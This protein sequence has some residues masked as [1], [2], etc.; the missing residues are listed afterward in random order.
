MEH[1]NYGDESFYSGSTVVLRSPKLSPNAKLVYNILLSY[2][3][4]G[5]E[6]FVSERRI[7]TDS[8]IKSRDKVSKALQEL[9]DHCLIIGKIVAGSHGGRMGYT[10]CEIPESFTGTGRVRPAWMLRL[11]RD[12]IS[13]RALKSYYGKY[14]VYPIK[15]HHEQIVRTVKDFELWQDILRQ[16]QPEHGYAFQ[17]AFEALDVLAEYVAAVEATKPAKRKRTAQ[18]K[19]LAPLPELAPTPVYDDHD[20]QYEQDDQQEYSTPE[21][22]PEPARDPGRS[23]LD[24]VNGYGAPKAQTEGGA[25]TRMPTGFLPRRTKQNAT[26]ANSGVS[27][28]QHS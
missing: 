15:E 9:K 12:T 24:V 16:Y 28:E 19:K 10:I 6:T 14:G 11:N 2:T 4:E 26:A 7:Y 18:P 3:D 1:G 25:P 27:A 8:C 21:P 20:D 17:P 22:A 13:N 23:G 5:G